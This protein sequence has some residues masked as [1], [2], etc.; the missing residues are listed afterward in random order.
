MKKTFCEFL[1][2]M[3]VHKC[4]GEPATKGA[5]YRDSQ[6]LVRRPCSFERWLVRTGLSALVAGSATTA[7][8]IDEG[9]SPAGCADCVI[10][11][12]SDVTPKYMFHLQQFPTS[13]NY[14]VSI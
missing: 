2:F 4:G 10:L 11:C 7:S 3:R 8:G 6:S 9:A 13:D 5:V 12:G 14:L 1:R